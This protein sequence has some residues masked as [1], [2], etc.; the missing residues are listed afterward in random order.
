MS[1][2]VHGAI[3]Q[4][5]SPIFNFGE[6]EPGSLVKHTFV[7]TNAGDEPMNVR[8]IKTPC[9]CSSATI[10]RK[11]L[12]GRESA[13]IA[14]TFDTTGC[15]GDV[16]K[17]ILVETDVDVNPVV[18]LKLEG[19]VKFALEPRGPSVHFEYRK[20]E[21][22]RTEQ[23]TVMASGVARGSEL[24]VRSQSLPKYL[25]VD[26]KSG[27]HD[28]YKIS[29]HLDLLQAPSRFETR[30]QLVAGKKIEIPYAVT[31]SGL[32]LEGLQSIPHVA[33]FGIMDR[34]AS[35]ERM[36]AIVPA[37][38][39][40]SI[41]AND[42]AITTNVFGAAVEVAKFSQK[43]RVVELQLKLTPTDD[44]K[45]VSGIVKIQQGDKASLEVPIKGY[46]RQ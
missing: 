31:V 20:G 22:Y 35:I 40:E 29:L 26:V 17:N 42:L 24:H 23:L 19:V 27:L 21:Q 45:V 18:T 41:Q 11:I 32:L 39:K 13:E 16:E 1:P 34:G 7:L 46:I 33:Y 14:V 30:I 44:S 43:G 8:Q 15:Y 3:P 38:S 12:K 5:I 25:K 9:S 36:I 2:V 28:D 6:V 4:L 10:D 37:D